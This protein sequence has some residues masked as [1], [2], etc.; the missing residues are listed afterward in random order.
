MPPENPLPEATTPEVPAFKDRRPLLVLFGVLEILIGS[1]CAL[2]VPLMLFGQAMAAKA[3]AA[4][5]QYRMILPGLVMYA[6]LAVTFLALGTGSIQARRWARAL[7]LILAWSWLAIGVIAT[8]VYAIVLPQILGGNAMTPGLPESARMV[9]V[10]ISVII[11]GVMFVALPAAL[12]VFYQGKHVKATC[13]AHDPVLRWTDRCP[14]PVLGLSLW[15][16]YAGVCMLLM[17]F[18]YNGVVPCFG[19]LLAGVPGMLLSLGIAALWIY[20]ARGVYRRQPAS[21]WILLV[22]WVLLGASAS[23]TFARVDLMEM[24]R[25]M[26]YP[27]AQI[28]LMQRYQ[29][30]QGG[31]MAWCLALGIGVML[32]YLLYVK[33]FF[34]RDVVQPG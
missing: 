14:L 34:R 6:L 31:G 33:K 24:Y 28:E 11:L 12:V 5:V 2:F 13:E 8:V 30:L 4:E 25:L 26:G 29:F 23:I 9:V 22:T 20:L 7:S 17:P 19:I 3:G 18:A 10:V 15:L 16:F 27:K 21:W 1:L 32:A